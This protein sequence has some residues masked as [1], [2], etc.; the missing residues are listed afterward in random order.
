ME[1]KQELLNKFSSANLTEKSREIT[2]S[3]DKQVVPLS[4]SVEEIDRVNQQ[5]KK[6]MD[7]KQGPYDEIIQGL[8]L[9]GIEKSK[10]EGL[11]KISLRF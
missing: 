10:K 8:K 11:F 6:S 5:L 1:E 7:K 3:D 2:M 9:L 4:R